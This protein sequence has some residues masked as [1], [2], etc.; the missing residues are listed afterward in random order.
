M[1]IKILNG[2]DVEGSMNITASDVPNLDASKITSG[3]INASRM[4][5]L[6]AGKVNS[7]S[8]STSRIP[9]LDASKITSGT[10]NAAR[11]P[12]LSSS[13]G[14]A[15]DTAKGVQAFEWGN[16]AEAGYLTSLPSHTHSYLPLSGGTLTGAL[17]INA[18]I[19]GNGQQ[20]VL[21]AG[22]SHSYATGQTNEYIY[23]NA[24]QGLE[25]NSH[26]GNWSGGWSTRK[27]AYLRG[28]Q[29][30]LDGEAMTKTN[31]QNFK[32]AYGWGNHGS[33]GYATQSWVNSQGFLTSETDSQTL[34]WNGTNGVLT[35][36]GGNSVDLDG[37]YLT[38]IPA[39]Y[40]TDTELGAV[41]S[42]IHQRIDDEII[43]LIAAKQ[44]A[45]S[46]L[47]T[48]GKA[49]DSNLLDGID[50]SAFLRSNTA[51][52]ASGRITFTGGVKI[53]GG[54]AGD[55]QGSELLFDGSNSP[56][57]KFRDSDTS[58]DDFYIHVNSNN[59]YILVDR[60][61]N[62]GWDGAHPLQLEGDTN[63]TYLF[64]NKVGNAAYQNTSAFDSAGSA[65]TAQA[66]AIA[67]ADDR[68][69]SEVL[70]AIDTKLDSSVNP[71]KGATVSNDTITFTRSDNTTFSVTTSDAN[72]NTWRGIDDTPVNG[73]TAESISSNWAY[74]H[75]NASNP[76]GTTAADVGADPAGSAAA[77]D[78]RIENDVIPELAKGAAAYGWG[79]HADAGYVVPA[80]FTPANY[81]DFIGPQGPAG[82]AGAK[83]D[84]GDTGPIGPQGPAGSAGAT[85]PQGPQGPSGSTGPQGPAG[86]NGSMYGPDKY[87]FQTGMVY[88]ANRQPIVL[89]G[90]E[91]NGSTSTSISGES[92]IVFNQAGTYLISWNI[93]WQ[94]Y[95]ANRST[96]GASAKLNG[97]T[98]QG[99]TNIQYFRYNTYGHK[100]TTASTF[101]VTV[102]VGDVLFFETFLHAGAINHGVT[103]T[104]GDGGAITIT[105]I[106]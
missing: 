105:R 45:G 61:N 68:I 18:Y 1:A 21:N 25:I 58:H 103:S 48:T 89:A 92:E 72:T 6:D 24:E 16:H 74:D 100:S 98:I 47:T 91:I 22:E 50:S 33:A 40:T 78:A 104:N 84:T 41:E 69:N 23:L 102:G 30:T 80:D 70:P 59:F 56:Q 2:V 101:A 32:T 35:I 3:T 52:T 85:G 29:L 71:I 83:G 49:A 60:D 27:T 5:N 88:E 34:S 64:G 55:A 42:S 75:V 94:S 95:Y 57:I 67:H 97:A 73:Q 37:R 14:T 31:I 4:P 36:S 39:S 87:L 51:D 54:N 19:K 38:S 15:A 66:N 90:Q 106:V 26:T 79:N 62:D 46:Y 86:A 99:G 8:F 11:I 93:N 17:T 12:N 53:Q 96:F 43:P 76:H 82:A 81:P 9:N 77:V 13:Y 7:G 65:S 20:L 63:S 28:D 10:L 44:D